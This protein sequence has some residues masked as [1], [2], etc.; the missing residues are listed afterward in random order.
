MTGLVLRP[1][2]EITDDK[3]RKAIVAGQLAKLGAGDIDLPVFSPRAAAMGHHQSHEH[4][5]QTGS[6]FAT[7]LYTG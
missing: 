3:L 2:H 1:P 4:V 5:N 7:A 6:N